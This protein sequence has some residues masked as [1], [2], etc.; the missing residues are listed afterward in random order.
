[1]VTATGH[2]LSP[3][4]ELAIGLLEKKDQ[5]NH[6]SKSV[7]ESTA[8]SIFTRRSE[9]IGAKFWNAITPIIIKIVTNP[10]LFLFFGSADLLN[11][12]SCQN[13]STQSS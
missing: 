2:L 3:A 6:G 10:I 11:R 12:L 7:I 1:M 13:M 4:R 8:S 5:G 9:S